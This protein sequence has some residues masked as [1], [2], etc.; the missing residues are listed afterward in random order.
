[1]ENYSPSKENT[2]NLKLEKLKKYCMYLHDAF[3]ILYRTCAFNL[4][5]CELQWTSCQFW[6]VFFDNPF[7]AIKC[8]SRVQIVNL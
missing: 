4:T 5:I 7:T 8:T 1:M 3:Y 6:I 2:V